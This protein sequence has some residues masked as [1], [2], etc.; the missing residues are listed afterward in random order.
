MSQRIDVPGG[1]GVVVPA[2]TA[3][4]V[5]TRADGARVIDIDGGG[6][7]TFLSIAKAPAAPVPAS[8][9]AR[10]GVLKRVLATL[11]PAEQEELGAAVMKLVAPKVRGYVATIKAQRAEIELLKARLAAAG[12]R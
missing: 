2:G 7:V 3:A 4:K 9:R 1:G 12:E 8:G 6:R 10:G 5:S 11:S